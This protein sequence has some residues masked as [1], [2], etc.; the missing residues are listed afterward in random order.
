M[1]KISYL[2]LLIL[3]EKLIQKQHVK[4]IDMLFSL[5]KGCSTALTS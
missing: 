4:L 3:I 2:Y 5:K 1:L